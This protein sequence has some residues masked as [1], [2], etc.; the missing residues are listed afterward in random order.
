MTYQTAIISKYIQ[1]R[2]SMMGI[3][4]ENDSV[5]NE[6]IGKNIRRLNNGDKVGVNFDA[7]GIPSSVKRI[8][9]FDC[10]HN[11]GEE[12]LIISYTELERYFNE[13]QPISM[14]FSE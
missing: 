10:L 12:A 11:L 3:Y 14:E 2:L 5:L 7:D 4:L 8:D 1:A 13:Q 6:L 9:G